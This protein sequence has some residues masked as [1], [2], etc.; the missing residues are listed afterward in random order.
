MAGDTIEIAVITPCTNTTASSA[1]VARPF[2]VTP[3]LVDS[4]QSWWGRVE[5][6]WGAPT[7]PTGNEVVRV[8]NLF[9]DV[10]VSLEPYR[11]VLLGTGYD[12]RPEYVHESRARDERLMRELGGARGKVN[13][14]IIR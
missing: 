2:S 1:P 10:G 6:S 4:G 13:R 12:E 9:S 5:F 7:A 14:E 11:D 3:G 8:R